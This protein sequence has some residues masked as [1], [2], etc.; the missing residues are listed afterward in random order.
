M[1][2]T[3]DSNNKKCYEFIHK[4]FEMWCKEEC[5]N[6][7][8]LNENKFFFN[9]PLSMNFIDTSLFPKT[10]S[11]HFLFVDF[12][13]DRLSVNRLLFNT[14]ELEKDSSSCR[15]FI[16]LSNHGA[17]LKEFNIIY[18]FLYDIKQFNYQEKI[19]MRFIN[20]VLNAFIT[21]GILCN[22]QMLS[23][24]YEN[25]NKQEDLTITENDFISNEEDN[26]LVSLDSYI[27][28]EIID[29]N[30]KCVLYN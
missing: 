5:S 12:R 16:L 15:S 8:N 10:K 13:L 2:I 4:K 19:L 23:K 20:T 11:V 7:S 6:Q 9:T 27:K 14:M 30:S 29:V 21:Y 22:A 28:C 1:I 26:V 24:L 25:K 17:Q 18:E 3:F